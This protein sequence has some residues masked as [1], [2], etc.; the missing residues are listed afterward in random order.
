MT[1]AIRAA[2][3][4]Q[5]HWCQ[6]LGSPF[7]ALLMDQIGQKLDRSTPVGQR[8]LDWPG[9]PDARF[10]A[11][12]LR[13]A[14]GLHALVQ[15]GTLPGLAALYPPNPLPTAAALWSELAQA[16]AHPD[17]NA[18]LDSAPQT[19]EVARSAMLMAGLMTVT[20]DTGLPIALWE[21]G[22]SAGLNLVLDRYRYTLGGLPAGQPGA[23]LHLA[24]EW[25]GPPPTVAPVHIASRRGADLNPVDVTNPADRERLLAYIWPD[26]AAR[27]DRIATAIGI[28]ATNPPPI[29][30]ADAGAWTETHV[31]PT[32]GVATVVMHSIAF[33]YFPAETQARIADHLAT[34]GTQTTAQAPL[35]WLR[36]EVDERFGTLP[37][38]ILTHWP[39]AT[40]RQLGRGSAHGIWA[41]WFPSHTP[42]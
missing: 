15:R 34:A 2:F 3:A 1:D 39:G 37:T 6:E 38:L 25:R 7:T 27:L 8:I 19:N 21:L 18:W 41:E 22:S 10:D 36:Y 13:L 16:L 29:D 20:H 26:Q 23:A 11:V 5:S 14:G 30:R 32:P 28:A 24:P 12:P 31:H 35:T 17:L 33:Q 4:Q 40:E 9:R 42:A